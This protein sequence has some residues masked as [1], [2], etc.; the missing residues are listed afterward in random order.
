MIV[1]FTIGHTKSYDQTLAEYLPE[2]CR[3]LGA[4][5]DYEGGWI[6]K[7]AAEAEA[8]IHSEDFLQVNWGDGK[9][10]SPENFSV[11]KVELVNGYQDISPIIDKDGI[12]NL[13]VSSRFYK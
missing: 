4:Q 12:Y 3:K 11:Y 2:E 1:A 13:L 10:R 9:F 6:W 7:T 8:F 5:D